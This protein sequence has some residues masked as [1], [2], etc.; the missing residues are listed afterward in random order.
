VNTHRSFALLRQ[1][2]F[3]VVWVIAFSPLTFYL[4]APLSSFASRWTF[5]TLSLHCTVWRTRPGKAA[6][7]RRRRAAGTSARKMMGYLYSGMD[8]GGGGE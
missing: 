1:H 6:N 4:V 7:R 2:R 8:G 3:G 5:A